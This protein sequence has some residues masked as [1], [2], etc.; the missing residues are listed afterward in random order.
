MSTNADSQ[1]LAALLHD[2]LQSRTALWKQGLAEEAFKGNG[3]NALADSLKQ[4]LDA[5][6]RYDFS[7]NPTHFGWWARL[8]GKD[9]LHEV[10]L[11]VAHKDVSSLMQQAQTHADAQLPWMARWQQIRSE[12]SA[13]ASSLAARIKVCEVELSQTPAQ[14]IT[15]L[16]KQVN[17]ARIVLMSAQITGQQL[18]ML[19]AKLETVLR[20]FNEVKLKLIPLWL[21]QLTGLMSGQSLNAGQLQAA[22]KAHAALSA[23]LQAEMSA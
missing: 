14:E 1:N 9:V 6:E 5:L 17:D 21:D 18:T 13:F 10:Q 23:R 4:L 22:A 15:N 3:V 16:Q 7:A 8:T 2:W 20:H 11:R 12:H 19:H